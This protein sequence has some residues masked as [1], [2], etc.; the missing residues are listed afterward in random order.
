M[1]AFSW[2]KVAVRVGLTC[3]KRLRLS[4]LAGSLQLELCSHPAG[5]LFASL[6]ERNGGQG[7]IRTH[8]TIAGT[9]L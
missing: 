5:F 9:H 1:A 4:P 2:R 7:G 6:R 3:R 8:G